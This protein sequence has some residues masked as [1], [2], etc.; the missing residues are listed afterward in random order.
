LTHALVLIVVGMTLLIAQPAAAQKIY[1]QRLPDGSVVYADHRIKGATLLYQVTLPDEQ[2]APTA[3]TDASAKSAEAAALDKRLRERASALDR[4]QRE[5]V[6][7]ERALE[8]AKHQLEVGKELLPGEL[9]SSAT[10]GTRVLPEYHERIKKLEDNVARAQVR[11]D[12]VYSERN[13]LR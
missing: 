10:G 7:A 5:V 13:Q 1:K 6:D 3:R 11:L 2:E 9:Q 12:R 8:E 4:V